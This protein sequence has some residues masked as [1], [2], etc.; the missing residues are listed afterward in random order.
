MLTIAIASLSGGQGKTTASLMLGRLLSRQGY[1]TL[2]IDADPQHNLTTY[3]DLDL[4]GNQPTLLELLKKSVS[5]ED[6]IYPSE[7]NDNLFLI[8]ADDQL[9]TVQDY[10]SNSG[11]GATL[12]KRRIEPVA[13]AFKVCIIDAPPQRSQIC[14]T[15][16][17]AADAL[18]IPAEASVKGYGSLV[19]TLDLLKTL[20]DVGATNAQVMGVLPFRDRWIG[21]TQTQE[22]RS[23]VDGMR[24]EVGESF[25]LPSIRESERYK[26]AINRRS[27]LGEMGYSDLEYPFEVLI[28][29]IKTLVK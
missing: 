19:R 11:V 23:A 22:S 5:A 14:L 16:L 21:K 4:Q 2:L 12:L 24:E 10:L 9:D 17:G 27:T 6:G 15:V 29:K 1:P 25:I 18:I 20:Q 26:Q 13:D 8:P 3:M 7:G 28:D